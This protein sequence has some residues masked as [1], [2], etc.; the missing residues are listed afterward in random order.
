MQITK[1][2]NTLTVT[3]QILI[4]DDD[5]HQA[6]NLKNAIDEYQSIFANRL[7]I[8]GAFINVVYSSVIN[9]NRATNDIN[10]DGSK[11]FFQSKRFVDE[12]L[13][14]IDII[15]CDFELPGK[16]GIELLEY[17]YQKEREILHRIYRVL[18]SVH[19]DYQQFQKEPY[20]DFVCDA[21]TKDAIKKYTLKGF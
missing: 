5:F 7:D 11:S 15:L 8:N 18:H 10:F 3:I 14:T 21:K 20:I 4:V 16:K 1:E 6:F 13:K 17:T 19:T 12:Q 2:D 9:G